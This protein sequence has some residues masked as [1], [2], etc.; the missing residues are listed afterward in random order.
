MTSDSAVEERTLRELYF[1]NYL[2]YDQAQ[3]SLTCFCAYMV[4]IVIG[5]VI[6]FPI[7]K[8]GA[9]TNERLLLFSA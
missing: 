5:E 8:L 6:I 1:I 7:Q 2:R 4:A 3:G 9:L